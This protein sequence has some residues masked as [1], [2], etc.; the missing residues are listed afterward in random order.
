MGEPVPGLTNAETELFEAGALAFAL[1]LTIPEGLGPIMNDVSCAACHNLPALGGWGPNTVIR[2]G[3]S[4]QG[5]AP[6][7]TLDALGGSLLQE[8]PTQA[9]LEAP[10]LVVV[11]PAMAMAAAV[12]AMEKKMVR[13]VDLI[14]NYLLLKKKTMKKNKTSIMDIIQL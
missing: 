2:F 1:G 4:S 9:R 5:G 8:Q 3:R 13:K 6:F 11:H 14:S 12:T 10:V 7:D